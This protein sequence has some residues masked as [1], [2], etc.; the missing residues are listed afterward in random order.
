M[1]SEHIPSD[2]SCSSHNLKE[3]LSS[4]PGPNFRGGMPKIAARTIQAVLT[5]FR[6]TWYTRGML[7]REIE[8]LRRQTVS[9]RNQ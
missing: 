5:E 7:R 3:A 8:P 1:R 9:S 2:G 4:E 6:R